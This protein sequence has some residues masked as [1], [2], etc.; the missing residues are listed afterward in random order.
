MFS[1]F[2]MGTLLD[3]PT[4]RELAKNYLSR[5][6]FPPKADHRNTIP[7]MATARPSGILNP[8]KSNSWL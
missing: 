3:L 2:G 6:D 8:V 7:P 5:F 1:R 4:C